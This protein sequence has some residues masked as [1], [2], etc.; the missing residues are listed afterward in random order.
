V[1]SLM[2]RPALFE[3]VAIMTA[4]ERLG[5]SP[6]NIRTWRTSEAHASYRFAAGPQLLQTNRP[7]RKQVHIQCVGYVCDYLLRLDTV[8]SGVQPRR[9]SS[10]S[11]LPGADSQN[12]TSHAAFG[13][14]AHMPSPSARPVV[15][16]WRRI[17]CVN[18][19]SASPDICCCSANN[20]PFQSIVS[21]LGG[22]ECVPS[23]TTDW[24]TGGLLLLGQAPRV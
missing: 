8:A 20:R 11:A 4:I 15:E 2:L 22:L 13:R 23:A 6:H 18:Y 19:H 10:D 9:E 21:H 1:I 12:A 5:I 3:S 17:S 16:A 14:Q 7:G 24:R